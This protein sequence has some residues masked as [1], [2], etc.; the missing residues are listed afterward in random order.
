M[1][2][3]HAILLLLI[4]LNIVV[5]I[6]VLPIEMGGDSNLI[7]WMSDSI[8]IEGGAKWVIHP[9]SV[10]GWYPYSYPSAVP[11]L[12]AVFSIITGLNITNL[13]LF[14]SVIF[15]V[16]GFIFSYLLSKQFFKD[17]L[18]NLS[19]AFAFSLN[20]VYLA[21]T[22]W[23]TTTRALFL[24]L[25]PLLLYFLLKYETTKKNKYLLSF[26]IVLLIEAA[27]HRMFFLILAIVIP[28]YITAKMYL[29]LKDRSNTLKLINVK[30]GLILAISVCLC[31]LFQFTPLY[32]FKE[33]YIALEQGMFFQGGSILV[34]FLNMMIDYVGCVGPVILCIAPLGLFMFLFKT[35]NIEFNSLFLVL[36]T[37]FS[38]LVLINSYYMP[39]FASILFALW[40]GMGVQVWLSHAKKERHK[41][42]LIISVLILI[43][44]FSLVRTFPCG[45]IS[46]GMF[47]DVTRGN[48]IV[49]SSKFIKTL[50]GN[51]LSDRKPNSRLIMAFT[52]KPTV[53]L[54]DPEFLVYE[55]VDAAKI[56]AKFKPKASFGTDY[57][58]M[59]NINPYL[60]HWRLFKQDIDSDFAKKSLSTYD[61]NYIYLE[62]ERYNYTIFLNIDRKDKIYENSRGELWK[63]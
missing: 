29:F 39:M 31:F 18:V 34:I 38:A 60:S 42:I 44:L 59:T 50:D 43:L 23:T 54:T 24:T 57:L 49:E 25:L 45:D 58:W 30:L 28:S 48:E 20:P 32:P 12:N 4:G 33:N 27:T 5:R 21:Y 53:P 3:E 16:L 17:E 63:L 2:K 62:E 61:I 14:T 13:I 15:G 7:H 52:Y 41:Q 37:L 56:N 46:F 11:H 1:R 40:F 55:F 19:V 8:I 47:K 35:K 9:A 26:F 6:P 36:M 22:K 51:I 10:F